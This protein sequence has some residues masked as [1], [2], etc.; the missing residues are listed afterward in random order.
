MQAQ[1]N[2]MMTKEHGWRGSSWQ[3]TLMPDLAAVSAPMAAC[4]VLVAI[5]GGRH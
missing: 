2:L 1:G 5:R 4:P 3:D